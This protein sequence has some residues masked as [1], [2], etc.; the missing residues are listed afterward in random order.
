[1]LA[2]RIIA[3]RE[4]ALDI[5]LC[6]NIIPHMTGSSNPVPSP[7]LRSASWQRK[8]ERTEALKAKL[9]QMQAAVDQL[10]ARERDEARKS[11]AAR[12]IMIGAWAMSQARKD[13]K[14][15]RYLAARLPTD[16]TLT[17]RQRT[18]LQPVFDELFQLGQVTPPPVP[19]VHHSDPQESSDAPR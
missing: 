9:K 10:E 5:S 17:E 15:G 11:D 6:G 16:A 7:E 4:T 18:L 8:R 13:E 3:A 14:F 19:A 1:M 2:Q 12:K